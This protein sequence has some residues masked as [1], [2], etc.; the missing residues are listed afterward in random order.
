[1]MEDDMRKLH[2]HTFQNGALVEGLICKGGAFRALHDFGGP[3]LLCFGADRGMP[4]LSD[5]GGLIYL[6]GRAEHEPRHATL[7]RL[8]LDA[9]A[10]RGWRERRSL[11]LLM[12]DDPE[13]HDSVIR[14]LCG[15]AGRVLDSQDI[16]EAARLAD[17][18]DSIYIVRRDFAIKH[19]KRARQRGRKHG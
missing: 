19:H 2:L 15:K 1:M 4:V 13:L 14:L 6:A 12:R 16:C 17:W 18:G 10:A 9:A 11:A 5:A 8:L 7:H 3:L